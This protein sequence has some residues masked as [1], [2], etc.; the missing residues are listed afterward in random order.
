MTLI[1][2]QHTIKFQP[3]V[4]LNLPNQF[5]AIFSILASFSRSYYFLDFFRILLLLL[6]FCICSFLCGS[7]KMGNNTAD[8]TSLQV[9]QF[10]LCWKQHDQLILSA[11]LSSLSIEVLHLVNC[12]TSSSVWRTL[13]QALASTSNSL[14][15]QLH[16]SF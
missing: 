14:S 5:L 16:G 3:F 1:N 8:G 2:Q 11:L 7:P 6:L 9:N 13:E 4:F 15:M 12:Q 10:F